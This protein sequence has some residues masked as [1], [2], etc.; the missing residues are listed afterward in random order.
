M[1][2]FVTKFELEQKIWLISLSRVEGRSRNIN[3]KAKMIVQNKKI[4]IS[5]QMTTKRIRKTN[6]KK[7]STEDF[8]FFQIFV[9]INERLDCTD[10]IKR[11]TCMLNQ[12][13]QDRV[14]FVFILTKVHFSIQCQ[15]IQSME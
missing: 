12:Y 11:R 4:F 3:I 5:E 15:N 10:K 6:L 14:T 2:T 8:L 7:Q 9:I 13:I 1:Q